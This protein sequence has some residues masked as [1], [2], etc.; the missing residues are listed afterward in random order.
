MLKIPGLFFIQKKCNSLPVVLRRKSER[1]IL[2]I[3]E[4]RFFFSTWK[5]DF[6]EC[7]WDGKNGISS[8]RLFPIEKIA[9]SSGRVFSLKN[10]K[11]SLFRTIDFHQDDFFRWQKY[12]L[13]QQKQ[14]SHQD[15]LF[16][17]KKLESHEE[18]IFI[19][20]RLTHIET[21]FPQKKSLFCYR[22]KL[23]SHHDDFFL[24]KR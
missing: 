14:E 15:D 12:F 2:S 18:N 20:K 16:Y 5:F 22:K 4:G 17:R 21:N 8:R 19:S 6:S 13:L 7:Y 23:E 3:D 1:A 9:V 24:Q 10:L 11:K